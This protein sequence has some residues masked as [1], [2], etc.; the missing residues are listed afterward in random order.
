MD[1][2]PNNGFNKNL[3]KILFFQKSAH[4]YVSLKKGTKKL[5]TWPFLIVPKFKTQLHSINKSTTLGK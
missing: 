4:L 3:A 2:K 1:F 5:N